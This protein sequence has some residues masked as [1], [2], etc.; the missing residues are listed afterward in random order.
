MRTAPRGDAP[1]FV[2]GMTLDQMAKHP[3]YFWL[4]T[5]DLPDP[6]TAAPSIPRGR[7]QLHYTFN[8][9]EPTRRLEAK[10]HT[11]L[12]YLGCHKHLI[13]SLALV[14]VLAHHLGLEIV[15]PAL[16]TAAVVLLPLHE[17]LVDLLLECVHLVPCIRK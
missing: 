1:R 11:I 4:M 2:P 7:A 3:V 6:T 13:P 14:G 16:Y 9:Q 15:G 5:E 8:N 17:L 10:L 12:E